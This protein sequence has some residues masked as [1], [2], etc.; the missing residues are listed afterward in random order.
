MHP[1]AQERFSLSVPTSQRVRDSPSLHLFVIVVLTQR[2]CTCPFSVLGFST[3]TDS[4]TNGSSERLCLR[5]IRLKGGIRLRY[6][7]I[8]GTGDR[9]TRSAIEMA[10]S[11]KVPRISAG[12]NAPFG[13]GGV[14][15]FR[16]D[17]T[18][19]WAREAGSM[20][21]VRG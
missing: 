5:S 12:G 1:P 19:C 4:I 17:W 20:K 21:S 14:H 10:G 9:N 7:V 11:L 18:A 15:L 8:T 2:Y 3:W 16:R 13:V 6:Y